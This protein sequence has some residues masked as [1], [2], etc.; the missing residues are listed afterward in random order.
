MATVKYTIGDAEKTVSVTLPTKFQV[1]LDWN[2]D[3]IL[4]ATGVAD[5]FADDPKDMYRYGTV[6]TKGNELLSFI[7]L[8]Q[9]TDTELESEESKNAYDELVTNYVFTHSY[10]EGSGEVTQTMEPI[11]V[12]EVSAVDPTLE[13]IASNIKASTSFDD[14][15]KTALVNAITALA[16]AAATKTPT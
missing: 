6:T 7:L 1:R 10:E 3:R 4:A 2:T 5:G 8:A 14:A 16:S 11:I 13:V 15:T 12:K 9:Y